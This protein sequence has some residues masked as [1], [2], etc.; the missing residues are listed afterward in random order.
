[1]AWREKLA[2]WQRQLLAER[3]R[4]TGRWSPT[5]GPHFILELTSTCNQ[6][7]HYCYNVW[8]QKPALAETVLDAA[9]WC[10]LI[11]KLQAETGCT[12]LTFSGGEPLTH[13]GFGEILAFCHARG[14]ESILIT[15]GGLLDADAVAFC[16]AHGVRMFEL[17]LLAAEP[18]THDALT[19]A[20]GSWERALSAMLCLQ[21]AE[22]AWCGVFVA[23]RRNVQQVRETLELLIALDASALMFNRCNPGGA[24]QL[25]L[26]PTVAQVREALAVVNELA[27]RYGVFATASIPI[28]PCLIETGPY[29]HVHFGFCSAGRENAYPTL[30]PDG[31][32]R[33]CNHS[34]TVLGWFIAAGSFVM[35]RRMV[36][37][38][39]LRAEGSSEPSSIEAVEIAHCG[40]RRCS[41]DWG[42]G[43]S[44][45]GV[46]PGSPCSWAW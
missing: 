41:P 20:P 1:M 37:G 40:W 44:S 3:A 23:T 18:A 19:R 16:L 12:R 24:A 13:P 30:G 9:G 2:R 11:A 43:C 8:K 10:A 33:P 4:L 35:G 28:M 29:R 6:D 25:A 38:L 27:A 31:R 14:L 21:Q 26:M 7:C 39:V 42:R 15:N 34:A 46:S 36:Q 32:V 45:S 5:T 22:A 17:T